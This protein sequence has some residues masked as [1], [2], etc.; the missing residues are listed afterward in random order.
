MCVCVCVCVCV[1]SIKTTNGHKVVLLVGCT[2][3]NG[4]KVNPSN[5]RKHPLK[6]QSTTAGSDPRGC[7]HDGQRQASDC[8]E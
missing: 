3:G 5:T 8:G 4:P 1:S 2:V 7:L 6:Q